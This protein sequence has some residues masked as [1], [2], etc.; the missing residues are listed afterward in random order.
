MATLTKSNET[1]QK[2]VKRIFINSNINFGLWTW[3]VDF[4]LGFVKTRLG[5][6]Y[7]IAILS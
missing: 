4:D 3:T 1:E 5:C 7:A 6:F 2:V